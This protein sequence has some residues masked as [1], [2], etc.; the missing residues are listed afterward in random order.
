MVVLTVVDAGD[1]QNMPKLIIY[2]IGLG[3]LAFT[4]GWIR[5]AMGDFL[6]FGVVIIYLVM[7]RLL[8]E[9]WGK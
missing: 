5:A 8:A 6:S 4:Q 3:P 2:I 1:K 7:L 9:R